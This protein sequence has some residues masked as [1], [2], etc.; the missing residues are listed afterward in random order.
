MQL[1]RHLILQW[2]AVAFF[3]IERHWP[4]RNLHKPVLDKLLKDHCV[5]A[6]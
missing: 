6:L 4:M 2:W 5:H 1:L 3:M